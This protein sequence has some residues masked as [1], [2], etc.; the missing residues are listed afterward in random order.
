MERVESFSMGW[1]CV[2]FPSSS[3]KGVMQHVYESLIYLPI[4]SFMKHF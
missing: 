3:L 2:S 4:L 1:V